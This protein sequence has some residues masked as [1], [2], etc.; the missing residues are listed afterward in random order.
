LRSRDQGYIKVL[1]SLLF[2]GRL[3]SSLGILDTSTITQKTIVNDNIT[4]TE[5]SKFVN[6]YFTG[7][8]LEDEPVFEIRSSAG[9]SGPAMTGILHEAK[10]LPQTL[11]KSLEI[12]VGNGENSVL[13]ML[14]KI[15]EQPNE[16]VKIQN[17]FPEIV[18]KDSFR[19]ITVVEDKELK[20]RVIAIFDYWSQACLKP[21]HA[22]VMDALKRIKSD[23]TFDQMSYKEKILSESGPFYSFDLKSATDLMPVSL[24]V[25]LVEK[26]LGREK[27]L[28]WYNIMV[29]YGFCVNGSSEPIHYATGQPMGAYSS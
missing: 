12:F 24:Q 21:F 22:F 9:P 27:A 4:D 17:I 28:A 1:L 26:I 5:I 15:R 25:K 3:H 29:G 6:M 7:V 19:K 20:N 18:L 14:N 13:Q 23:C 16:E 8:V 10:L 2:I 11:V